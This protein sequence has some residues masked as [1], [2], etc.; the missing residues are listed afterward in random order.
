MT[1]SCMPT[2]PVALRPARLGGPRPLLVAR[3]SPRRQWQMAWST[4]ARKTT[5]CTPTRQVLHPMHAAV[6]LNCHRQP[7]RLVAGGGQR[8]GLRRLEDDKLYAYP[9]TCSTPCLR[10]GPRPTGATSTPRRRWPTASFTSARRTAS[11]TRSRR[12][13]PRPARPSGPRRPLG[14]IESSPAVANG[15]VYV[16][17][18]DGKLYA[19]PASC[20]TPCSPSWSSMATGD[21][22]Y[23]SPAVAGG[24]VHIGS[25]DGKL[26]A[27]PT[28][29]STPCAP[30]WSSASTGTNIYSSPAVANRRDLRWLLR[31]QAA[32]LQRARGQTITG[33]RD[34]PCAGFSTEFDAIHSSPAV[35]KGVV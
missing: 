6:V 14:G 2:P 3:S 1:A 22:I 28:S 8:R 7:H 15:V 18:V 5:S 32:R 25:D 11:C 35:A 12:P 26:Y 34:P 17:S 13:V 24:V 27:Y 21:K 31:P 29:C 33:P 30:L 9:A 19:F 23:S 10:C 4:S 20:S 16:G